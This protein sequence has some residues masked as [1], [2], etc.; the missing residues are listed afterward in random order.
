[1][2]GR[3]WVRMTV[4][5]QVR[6]HDGHFEPGPSTELETTVTT[7]DAAQEFVRLTDR[8]LEDIHK[9]NLFAS[10]RRGF[11][12]S[13]APLNEEVKWHTIKLDITY[14]IHTRGVHYDDDGTVLHEIDEVREVTRPI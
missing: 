6:Y 14:R 9:K 10:V 12:S 3:A 1:M 7:D 13:F 8:V 5:S 4:T 11:L 2:K